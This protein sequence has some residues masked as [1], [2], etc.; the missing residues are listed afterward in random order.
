MPRRAARIDAN[1][2]EIVQ[3]LRKIGASVQSLAMVGQGVPDLLVGFRGENFLFEIKDGD[4]PPSRRNLTSDEETWH[5]RWVGQ[6]HTVNNIDE[7]LQ[8]LG[9]L[10]LM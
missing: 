8:Y 9:L 2:T 5:M 3:M 1:Q 4:K 7:A 10:D 6:V